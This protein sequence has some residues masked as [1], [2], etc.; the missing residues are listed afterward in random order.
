MPERTFRMPVRPI[1]KVGNPGAPYFVA[2][3]GRVKIKNQP[4]L[5][6]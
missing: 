4:N 6:A 3:M 1:L 2:F 5:S